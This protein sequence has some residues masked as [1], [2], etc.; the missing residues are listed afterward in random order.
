MQS[1]AR[2]GGYDED[3]TWGRPPSTYLAPWQVAHLLILRSRL[4]A[5]YQPRPDQRTC[6]PPIPHDAAAA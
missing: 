6:V 1:D 5:E 2:G 3:Y 4:A